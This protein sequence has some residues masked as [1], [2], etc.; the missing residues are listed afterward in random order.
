MPVNTAGIIVIGDEVLKGQ[1]ADSNVSFL[2]KKLHALGIRLC[3]VSIIPDNIDIIAQEVAEYSSKYDQVITTGGIGPTH[4][5]VTYEGVSAAFAQPLVTNDKLVTYWSW[6]N[7]DPPG[8][9]QRTSTVKM[10]TIPRDSVILY[11]NLPTT[12]IPDN[13]FP[14]I[15]VNNVCIL[16][17]LPKYLR[18]IFN[19]LEGV[20][21]KSS[22]KKFHVRRI[23]LNVF[24]SVFTGRL[25]AAVN[26][27]KDV[28]FGS[29][30][31]LNNPYYKTVV[32]MEAQDQKLLDEAYNYFESQLDKTW[33]AEQGELLGDS[34][35]RTK[36]LMDS[37]ELST[38]NFSARLKRSVE[39][40]DKCLD[41]YNLPEIFISFNGGK[42]CTVLVHLVH[43][44]ILK[45]FKQ[46]EFPKL[47]AVYIRTDSPFK[48]VEDFISTTAQRYNLNL[49][50]E[51]GPLQQGIQNVLK[52]NQDFKVAILGIRKSDPAGAGLSHIQKTDEGWGNLLRVSPLLDW[53][54]QDIWNYLRELNIPYCPLYDLGYTSLGSTTNSRPNSAL[55]YTDENGETKYKPAY[56][57]EDEFLERVGRQ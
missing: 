21:F 27:Y 30:P 54:Y 28:V 55:Q 10:A 53:S 57:L 19:A 15:T 45:R 17:G 47:N 1:V 7:G 51:E 52:S 50:T 42:D 29:Y 38:M 11:A 41:E 25:N 34:W 37:D 32:T 8:N 9:T 31:K 26:K 56:C 3:K 43:S 4:D 20:Y 35:I 23:Y 18:A 16:P 44:V 39:I 46:S 2:A 5:D 6:F 40:L 13:K 24:E 12:L 33:L 22:G 36:E 48:E 14:V 49:I